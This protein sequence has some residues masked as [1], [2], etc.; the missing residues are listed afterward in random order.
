MSFQQIFLTAGSAM[1]AQTVRL[2][3]ISS[4]LANADSF[5][6]NKEDVFKPLKPIFATIYNNMNNGSASNIRS[7]QVM[8]ADVI[9]TDSLTQQRH[10]PENPL[11]NAEGNVFYSGIDVVSEMADM[12]SASRSFEMNV[13]VLNNAKSMQQSLISVLDI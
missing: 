8:V 7:A 4:N 5:S 2:N 6:G 10:E 9:A 1:T 13:E 3:T 12:M 11:A